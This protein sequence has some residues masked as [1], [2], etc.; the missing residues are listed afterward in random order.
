MVYT[1]CQCEY[2]FLSNLISIWVDRHRAR[3]E[4]H[5]LNHSVYIG[6]D[7]QASSESTRTPFEPCCLF[8]SIWLDRRRARVR[9]HL[10]SHSIF[11]AVWRFETTFLD[12]WLQFGVSLDQRS[13]IK[14][15]QSVWPQGGVEMLKRY[16][17]RA[18]QYGPKGVPS[19]LAENQPT[20][21]FR[22]ANSVWP[23]LDCARC[24]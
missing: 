2:R 4:T 22:I 6:L 21:Q 13:T 24:V 11:K 8:F 20:S 5:H 14:L 19:D 3:V 7:G 12:V 10:L 15:A 17:R 16:A 18:K 9:K 23:K 1:S